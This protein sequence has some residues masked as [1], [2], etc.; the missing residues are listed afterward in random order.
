MAKNKHHYVPQFYLRNFASSPKRINL[1]NL[2]TN[3]SFSNAGLKDQCYRPK[4]YGEVDDVENFLARIEA[5]ASPVLTSIIDTNTLPDYDSNEYTLL[6]MFIA[7]QMQRTIG[8]ANRIN[9]SVDGM[10]KQVMQE[11][12]SLTRVDLEEYTIGYGNPSLI[13]LRMANDIAYCLDDLKHHII[14][15][16][17]ERRFITSD[18]PVFSYNQYCE[19][20]R[21]MG[22]TG[23]LS[24]GLQVFFPLSPHVLLM[25][26]DGSV[27]KPAKEGVHITTRLT[28]GELTRI[29]LMQAVSADEHVYFSNWKDLDSAQEVARRAGRYRV[30]SSSKTQILDEEGEGQ[31]VLIHSYDQ[32]PNLKLG[33]SFLGIREQARAVPL[34]Q[35][36][37]PFRREFPEFPE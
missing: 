33:L 5:D 1:Y 18:N 27:Y 36:T 13:S 34:I 10:M 37:R 20:L 31:S 35:R 21:D 9:A 28:P 12:P 11:A 14:R 29:N 4:L 25:L 26:Y 15:L 24:R 23:A 16:P 2:R 32:M 6:M 22:V 8:T 19:G 30:Q 7:L 17:K 3:F